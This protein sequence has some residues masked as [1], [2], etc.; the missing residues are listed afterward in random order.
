[1][2]TN[3]PRSIRLLA[4]VAAPLLVAAAAVVQGL[5][6]QPEKGQVVA[7]HL[8][9]V[10]TI[11][12]ALCA[13][14]GAR[15]RMTRLEFKIDASVLD[16]IPEELATHFKELRIYQAGLLTM[17]EGAG[18]VSKY[19]YALIAL[20]GNNHVVMFRSREGGGLD[21]TESALVS[22]AS[23]KSRAQDLLFVGGDFDNEPFVAF[24]REVAKN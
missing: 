4:F 12:S 6:V 20:N 15:E 8:E 22:I 24:Q 3:H 23:G 18:D 19:P 21:D 5:R 1:M 16:A 2:R 7:G 11:D 9:G 13:R 17:T 14:I 10:W